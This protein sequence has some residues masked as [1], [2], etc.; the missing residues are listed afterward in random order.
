MK[1][2]QT[3]N[4]SPSEVTRLLDCWSQ[5]EDDAL[6]RLMPLIVEEL[7][8]IA[9]KQMSRET[10]GHTLEPTALVNELYLKLAGR[11]T[12]SWRNRAQFFAFVAGSMRRLLVDHAR[13]R[14]T[15]K[16]GGDQPVLSLDD[17]LRLPQN[18]KNP[19]LIAL[20]EALQ[21]LARLDPRQARIVEMRYFT[22]LEIKEIATVEGISPTTVKREWRTARLWLVKAIRH[23]S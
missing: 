3:R 6:P 1:M 13:G 23:P 14:K 9:R 19:D 5:G 2:N 4:L 7:R 12:V 17:S 10:P 11:R 16:R 18:E 22:G 20:D 21:T 8:G 15:A